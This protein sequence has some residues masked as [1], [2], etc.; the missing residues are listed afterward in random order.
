VGQR[1]LTPAIL[2]T[3]AAEPALRPAH[4]RRLTAKSGLAGELSK[5]E[6]SPKH[7]VH[8][9]AESIFV[10]EHA[11]W[12]ELNGRLAEG[13]PDKIAL[14]ELYNEGGSSNIKHA[15]E[16]FFNNFEH[17]RRDSITQ[18]NEEEIVIIAN[19]VK[20]EAFLHKWG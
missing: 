1:I 2:P 4:T 7:Q 12:D 15:W 10:Q 17:G 3:Q 9:E 8:R 11:I 6:S 5:N 18:E 14:E 13:K 16:G 19:E 20:T